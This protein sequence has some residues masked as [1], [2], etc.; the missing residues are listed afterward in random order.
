MANRLLV[1]GALAIG[2]AQ[3]GRAQLGGTPALDMNGGAGTSWGG[4][5]RYSERGAVAA[6]VTLAWRG[7]T[8]HARVYALSIGGQASPASGDNCLIPPGS[9]GCAPQFPGVSHIALLTGVEQGAS[10][11]A[12]RLLVGPAFFGGTGSSGAGGQAQIDAAA[13]F[14]HLQLV[15]ALRGSLLRRFS[16]ETFRL[17]SF[18]FGLRIQ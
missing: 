1:A 13:G 14:R 9:T 18:G 17:G 11:D 7:R 4:N 6:E 10:H 15:A 12:V 2:L 3:P 5:R 8:E 16:G